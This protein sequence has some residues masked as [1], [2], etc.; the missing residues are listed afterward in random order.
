MV[1]IHGE[2]KRLIMI[3][4]K[5]EQINLQL[6]ALQTCKKQSLT[7]GWTGQWLH[8]HIIHQL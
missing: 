1:L 7:P 4:F 8:G 6:Q 2:R 3:A 5:E